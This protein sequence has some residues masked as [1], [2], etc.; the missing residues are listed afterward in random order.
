MYIKSIKNICTSWW[1]NYS[2][3]V[4]ENG[5]RIWNIISPGFN[6]YAKKVDTHVYKITSIS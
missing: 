2:K 1:N 5:V 6:E 3:A 4:I